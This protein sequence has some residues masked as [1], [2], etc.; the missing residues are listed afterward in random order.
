MSSSPLSRLIIVRHAHALDREEF[1][2]KA[3]DDLLRPLSKKG[4]AQSQ[5]ITRFVRDFLDTKSIDRLI[6]SPATRA[7]QT[8]KPLTKSLPHTPFEISTL[9]APD[10]G[11]EGYVRLLEQCGDSQTLLIVGHQPDIGLFVEFLTGCGALT[12]KKG[13]VLELVRRTSRDSDKPTM[14]Q[15]AF[16]LSLLIDPKRL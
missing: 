6:S 4:K 8:I 12:I 9:I 14:W 5:K 7:L 15:N 10:C 1:A 2:H 13:C 3:P 16:R 11:Y